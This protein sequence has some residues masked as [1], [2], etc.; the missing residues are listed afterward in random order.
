MVDGRTEPKSIQ[1]RLKPGE[2]VGDRKRRNPRAKTSR[3]SS[4]LTDKLRP[5][6]R[7]DSKRANSKTTKIIDLLKKPV[8]ASLQELIALTEWQAHSVRGFL[9]GVL[10]KK[11]GL[12][13]TSTKQDGV[14]RYFV[15]A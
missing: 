14:R 10:G 3:K 2:K 7:G 13:V 12:A 8:G 5:E 4:I 15:K 6:P 1:T 11:M 9:S